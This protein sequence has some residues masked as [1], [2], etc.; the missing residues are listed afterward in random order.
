MSFNV[1]PT[2]GE[3]L[4]FAST[5]SQYYYRVAYWVRDVIHTLIYNSVHEVILNLPSFKDK[6]TITYISREDG[7]DFINITIDKFKI[8]ISESICSASHNNLEG[9]YLRLL[10]TN[11][12]SKNIS[13]VGRFRQF[14]YSLNKFL[15]SI[16]G[17]IDGHLAY[18]SRV[19]WY[20]KYRRMSVVH[21]LAVIADRTEADAIQMCHINIPYTIANQG[22]FIESL[23]LYVRKDQ[24]K[25]HHYQPIPGAQNDHIVET[26]IAS[27][28]IL[29]FN[30]LLK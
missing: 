23:K 8:S 26:N 9:L 15:I 7:K 12:Y 27:E 2:G 28:L 20:C 14:N 22:L 17:G 1:N 24:Y 4:L 19:L 11:R 10:I 29:I 13:D 18:E 21:L 16:R 6:D 5:P 3:S 30:Q 25:L